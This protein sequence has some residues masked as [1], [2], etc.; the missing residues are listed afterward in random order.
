MQTSAYEK[1]VLGGEEH[2]GAG[3][4]EETLV[5]HAANACVRVLDGAYALE[6]G[7]AVLDA[8]QKAGLPPR[9]RQS[10]DD[11]DGVVRGS[12]VNDNHL[13]ADAGSVDAAVQREEDGDN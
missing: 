9:Q 13:G 8:R 6:S 3:G 5:D 11:V 2:K 7:L 10:V 4:L 12:G 1:E